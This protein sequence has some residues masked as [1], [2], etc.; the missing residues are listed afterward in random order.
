MKKVFIA[1]MLMSGILLYGISEA[2]P[3]KLV[4]RAKSKDA[5]FVGTTMGGAIVTIKD[6]ETGKVLANGLTEGSTG[7]TRKIMIEPKTRFGTI[8][9]GSAKFETSINV[10]EPTLITIDVDAPF[11]T[12]PHMIRSSTQMWLIPGKDITGEGIIIE[13]PGFSVVASAPETVSMT[14]RKAVIPFQSQIVMI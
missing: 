14:D 6:S 5:K 1:A 7:D 9:D 8:S 12:K 3:T 11:V 4:I 10:Y 13:I 2:V